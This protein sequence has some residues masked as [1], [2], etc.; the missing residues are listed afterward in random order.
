MKVYIRKATYDYGQL[1]L[2]FFDLMDALGGSQIKP[3]SRVLIKPNLLRSALP[4]EGI[5]THPSLVR[6]AVEYVLDRGAIPLVADSPAIGSFERL[7]TKG[8]FREALA[9]HG[10]YCREFRETRAVDIGAPF[11]QIALAA[12]AL[13]ADLIINLPKLKTHTQMLLTLGVKNMF[14]AVVG[15]AKPEWHLKSGVERDI[16]ARL[17]V[18]IYERLKPAFTILDGIVALEGD[19]PGRGGRPRELGIIFGSSCAHALDQ[20]VCHLLRI[21]PSRLP[22]H[23]VAREMGLSATSLELDGELPPAFEFSLPSPAPVIFGPP[24]LQNF[25]RRH[26][27]SNPL[28]RE[29][30]CSLCGECRQICPVAAI[31]YKDKTIFNLH[32]CIRCHCCMEICPEGAI[33]FKDSLAGRL[34]NRLAR[35]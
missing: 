26:T 35:A 6:A 3:Q 23:K 14:G 4:K 11:W 28:C 22:T 34:I 27:L 8:G 30:L 29:N 18:L 32:S 21:E 9:G 13:D 2:L 20:A 19:G 5:I 24:L 7:L 33:K 10:D 17:L 15:F 1:R 16:F 31:S 12:D 25:I